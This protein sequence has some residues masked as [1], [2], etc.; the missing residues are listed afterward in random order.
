MVTVEEPSPEAYSVPKETKRLLIEGII[1]NPLIA[2]SLP[3][4]ARQYVKNVRYVGSDAPSIPINWRFAESI[5]SLKGL[6]ATILNVLLVKK[7][8]IEPQEAVINT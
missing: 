2:K 8:G 7:Y 3:E 1:N 5:A 6:E 4:E